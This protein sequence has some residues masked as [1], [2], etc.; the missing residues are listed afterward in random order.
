[1]LLRNDFVIVCCALIVKCVL[2]VDRYLYC[3]VTLRQTIHYKSAKITNNK[4]Y[5]NAL[6]RPD[7]RHWRRKYSN[8]PLQPAQEIEGQANVR[9]PIWWGPS[10][11]TPVSDKTVWYSP[12]LHDF[13]LSKG[14]PDTYYQSAELAPYMKAFAVKRAKEF[15]ASPGNGGPSFLVEKR[16]MEQELMEEIEQIEHKMRQI[17]ANLS[18][19]LKILCWIM[20]HWSQVHSFRRYEELSVR[21]QRNTR[22][23]VLVFRLR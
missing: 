21:Q 3:K 7:K 19:D 23:A 10:P 2:L 11:T 9:S 12:T 22:I 4:Y 5:W 17:R 18:N 16:I 13:P 6:K 20:L 14:A 8:C 15:L 1:M